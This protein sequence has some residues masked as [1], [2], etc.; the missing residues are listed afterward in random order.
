MSSDDDSN[1][2]PLSDNQ[3]IQSDWCTTE[4]VR[5]GEGKKEGI[6][7]QG[8]PNRVSSWGEGAFLKGQRSVEAGWTAEYSRSLRQSAGAALT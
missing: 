5:L 7:C 3:R 4:E 1:S 2:L 8:C 6:P